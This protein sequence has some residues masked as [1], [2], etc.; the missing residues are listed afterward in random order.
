MLPS[1][2]L[3]K[4][5]RPP[6]ALGPQYSAVS[7]PGIF[8]SQTATG[9]ALPLPSGLYSKAKFSVSPSLVLYLSNFSLLPGISYSI[10]L[11][12]FFLLSTFHYENTLYLLMYFGYSLSPTPNWDKDKG[13]KLKSEWGSKQVKRGSFPGVQSQLQAQ[14]L[15][16][17][18]CAFY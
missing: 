12:Y 13:T 14:M 11:L 4:D 18:N 5:V 15:P 3:L 10:S 9:S 16:G 17:D 1:S 8:L 6:F 7:P 2:L